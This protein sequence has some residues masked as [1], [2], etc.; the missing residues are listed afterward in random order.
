MNNTNNYY[1]SKKNKN[2]NQ[3]DKQDEQVEQD[4]Q[5]KQVNLDEKKNQVNQINKLIQ[6]K[7]MIIKKQISNL[8]NKYESDDKEVSVIKDNLD[9]VFFISASPLNPYASMLWLMV[10]T[11]IT[12]LLIE[13]IN[14][15][16]N[17]K[18]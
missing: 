9:P 13:Y 16:H 1:N 2:I 6:D 10:L 12:F 18:I 17:N 14:K 3:K 8:L 7:N 4:D 5:V 15:N 11:I